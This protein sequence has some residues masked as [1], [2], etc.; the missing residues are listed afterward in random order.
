MVINGKYVNN[1]VL[2][3]EVSGGERKTIKKGMM[4]LLHS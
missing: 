4:T 2:L 1:K 3:G